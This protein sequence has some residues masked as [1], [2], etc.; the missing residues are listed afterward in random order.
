MDGEMHTMEC[1]PAF[2]EGNPAVCDDQD[3]PGERYAKWNKPFTEKYGMAP[4]IWRIRIIK[5][6]D[7]KKRM[8]VAG[9]WGEERMQGCCSTA[10]KRQ[11]CETDSFSRS[12]VWPGTCGQQYCIGRSTNSWGVQSSCCVITTHATRQK[13][14]S[15]GDGNVCHLDCGDNFTGVCTG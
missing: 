8:G 7:T 15:G 9:D 14:T 1:D 6:I 2:R 12:K 3:E 11:L 4:L 5:L 13:D 10:T